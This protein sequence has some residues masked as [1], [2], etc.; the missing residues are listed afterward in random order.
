M[1]DFETFK[2]ILV[3][4]G[5]VDLSDE[6]IMKLRDQQDQMAEI[7]FSSWLTEVNENKV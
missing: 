2:Q 5:M 1:I 3:K 7:L 4:D 6:Q